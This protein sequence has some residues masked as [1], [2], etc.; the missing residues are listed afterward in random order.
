[1]YDE[2]FYGFDFLH[3]YFHEDA[4]YNTGDYEESW[5]LVVE[6]GFWLRRMIDGSY[7]QCW[8]ALSEVLQEYD[9]DFYEYS[10]WPDWEYAYEEDY[11]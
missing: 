9:P 7:D 10:M 2:D 6:A 1:M 11:D 3:G 4:Y 5:T 8:D